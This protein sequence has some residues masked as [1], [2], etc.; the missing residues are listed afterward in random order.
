MRILLVDN[1]AR[2]A[3]VLAAGLEHL[4][5]RCMTVRPECAAAEI[6]AHSYDLAVVDVDDAAGR[7]FLG[8]YRRLAPRLSVVALSA[9]PTVEAAVAALAGGA[10]APALDYIHK[11]EA[12]LVGR[13]DEIAHRQTGRIERGLFLADT[14]SR[15][16]FY[17][18]ERLALSDG[19]FDIYLAF[20]RHPYREVSYEELAQIV[21]AQEMTHEDAYTRYRSPV[22]R[23]RTELRRV[24]GRNVLSRHADDHGI[25]FVPAGIS[26]R[27]PVQPPVVS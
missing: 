11:P 13:I 8:E 19:E 2:F 18:G 17:D 15:A 20:M 22:S 3:G 12:R 5:H 25:R 4:G 10:Q 26:R 21:D 6:A 1:D 7:T 9:E 23:V 14:V 16:G 27:R 24:A